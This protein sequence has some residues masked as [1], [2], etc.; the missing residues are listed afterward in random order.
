MKKIALSI[1]LLFAGV[2]VT[3]HVAASG[4]SFDLDTSF[5]TD[6][7]VTHAQPT[8]VSSTDPAD[9]VIDSFGRLV[10]LVNFNVEEVNIISGHVGF[11][12]AR[13][14]VDGQVDTT[15]GIGGATAP[16]PETTGAAVVL[17]PDGTLVVAA[18]GTDGA[19]L[20]AYTS[21]GFVK[22]S[23]GV[24]GIVY[25]SRSANSDSR[26]EIHLKLQGTRLVVVLLPGGRFSSPV[27]TRVHGFTLNGEID[28]SYGTGGFLTLQVNQSIQNFVMTDIATTINDQ[29]LLMGNALLAPTQDQINNSSPAMYAAV[30][31]RLT[32]TGSVDTSFANYGSNPPGHL[33]VPPSG[34]PSIEGMQI[35]VAKTEV[36][37]D[38]NYG[39]FMVAGRRGAENPVSKIF[40][41][42]FTANGMSDTGFGSS[43]ILDTNISAAFGDASVSDVLMLS[44]GETKATLY[45]EISSPSRSAALGI[46]QAGVLSWN[47]SMWLGSGASMGIGRILEAPEQKFIVMAST[48]VNL[49]ANV[50]VRI[51]SAGNRDPLYGNAG[52]ANVE[53]SLNAPVTIWVTAD[54]QPNGMLVVAGT[55]RTFSSNGNAQLS[56]LV[57][58]LTTTGSL[59]SNFGTNGYTVVNVANAE[60]IIEDIV[61]LPS[62][63]ILILLNGYEGIEMSAAH[64]SVMRL[65]TN[66][67]VDLGFGNGNGYSKVADS[68]EVQFDPMQ[69]PVE[70]TVDTNGRIVVV[71]T[72][73]D[74]NAVSVAF[75]QRM[76]ADGVIDAS[77]DGATGSGNGYVTF[78][79]PGE[80]GFNH[81][82]PD[83]SGKY[84]VTGHDNGIP[85]IA[86]LMP[87]GLFDTSFG[88]PASPGVHPIETSNGQG[89]FREGVVLA[90]AELPDGRVALA[91]NFEATSALVGAHFVTRFA[92]DGTPDLDYDGSSGT[93]NGL[94]LFDIDA[95]YQEIFTGMSAA[96]DGSLVLTGMSMQ[97]VA[98]GL[99]AMK[100]L[101]IRVASGGQMGEVQV[102]EGEALHYGIVQTTSGEWIGFGSVSDSISIHAMISRFMMNS[103]SVVVESPA[104]PGA[105]PADPVLV[106]DVPVVVVAPAPPSAAPVVAPNVPIA[107]VPVVAPVIAVAAPT[108]VVK[109]LVKPVVLR[110]KSVSRSTLMKYLKLT[111][112]KGSK[113][114]IT[115]SAKSK[116]FCTLKKT[117]IVYARPGKCL[118]RVT[119]RPKKGIMR[120]ATTTMVVKK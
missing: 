3:G 18:I 49:R 68:E 19:T 56:G 44:N 109:K 73:K 98:N 4:V 24:N 94:V 50:Y 32:S 64:L 89:G 120:S 38:S 62:G 48:N 2:T 35:A 65:N 30:V 111:M 43:G 59:D 54:P 31:V 29:L 95:S 40:F 71:G 79:F 78:T 20:R 63:K 88:S 53:V 39:K 99:G 1:A 55:I 75:M 45:D 27:V 69:S 52:L 66:G 80:H 21:N 90:L 92:S 67:S 84:L 23:F 10:S 58:R 106:P 9:G 17:L 112:P 47:T 85:F 96:A 7:T 101:Y 61:V 108:T 57:A 115:V 76:N 70:M 11:V 42:R 105:V 34:S 26:A 83:A 5:G 104:S 22:N 13:H 6:G 100:G 72:V 107:E 116:R 46:S 113:V 93:G 51:D 103:P 118:V 86:R 119:V 117:S 12:V 82:A 14:T 25:V 33:V 81:I 91:G 74:D 77:F 8:G 28:S 102:M 110:K 97:I 87:D 114:T 16:V 37:A 60:V 41:A 15:F 36:P